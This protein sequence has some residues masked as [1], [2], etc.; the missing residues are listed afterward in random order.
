MKLSTILNDEITASESIEPNVLMFVDES[1]IFW[2]SKDGYYVWIGAHD[3]IIDYTD[4]TH[5][6]EDRVYTEKSTEG[7]GQ[8]G[9]YWMNHDFNSPFH[10][11][12]FIDR[13]AEIN[14]IVN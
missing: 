2:V 13:I 7:V 9:V 14:A 3:G 6:I 4:E 5:V 8:S 10:I 12:D 11:S 1:S